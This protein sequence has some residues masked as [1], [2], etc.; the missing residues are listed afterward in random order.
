MFRVGQ[1]VVCVDAASE[2]HLIKGHVYTVT[3]TNY[4][5]TYVSVDCCAR[6]GNV[7]GAGWRSFRFRPIVERKT[8]ISIFKKMLVPNTEKV[9]V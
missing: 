7:D 2:A 3:R 9:N 4:L 5:P 6:H 8:D 1:K